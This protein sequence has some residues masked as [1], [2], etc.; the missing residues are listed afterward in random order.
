MWQEHADN[1]TTFDVSDYTSLYTLDILLRC[2]FSDHTSN[3][4]VE[5]YEGVICF[6]VN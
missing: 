3:C 4:L 6:T 2:A 5:K 1:E